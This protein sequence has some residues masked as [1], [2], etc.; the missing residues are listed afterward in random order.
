MREMCLET[1][2]IFY[3]CRPDKTPVHLARRRYL[4]HVFIYIVLFVSLQF[5]AIVHYY[6]ECCENKSTFLFKN[7]ALN[8]V[9]FSI[10]FEALNVFSSLGKVL[11]F[12]FRG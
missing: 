12:E 2:R 6:N 7:T 5:H 3:L 8:T 1:R 9:L 10:H 11:Q 4:F